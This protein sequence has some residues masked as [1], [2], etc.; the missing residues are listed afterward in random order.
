MTDN[1][2]IQI[3][4]WYV[5][6]WENYDHLFT[7]FSVNEIWQNNIR[8]RIYK[9]IDKYTSFKINKLYNIFELFD[10]DLSRN[11]KFR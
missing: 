5:Q 11:I 3:M 8:I 1:D 9:E 6:W 4:R 7:R 2:L 10:H